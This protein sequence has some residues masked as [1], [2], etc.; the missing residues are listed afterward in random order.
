MKHRHTLIDNI[1]EGRYEMALEGENAVMEYSKEP[2]VVIL[3]HTLVPRSCEGQ[4]IG[5]EMVAAVLDDIRRKGL[6]VVPSCPFVAAYIERHPEWDDLVA[7]EVM[8]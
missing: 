6:R 5:S 8:G 1:Y 7:D 2:G 4:G 3:T